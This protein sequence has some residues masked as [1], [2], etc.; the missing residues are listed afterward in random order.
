M[1]DIGGKEKYITACKDCY[2][3]LMEEEGRT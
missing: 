1:I 3:K 2:K